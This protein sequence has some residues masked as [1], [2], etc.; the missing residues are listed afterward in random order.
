MK[1]LIEQGSVLIRCYNHTLSHAPVL[2]KTQQYPDSVAKKA[3][4]GVHF[5]YGHD[6]SDA[7]GEED[8]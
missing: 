3:C 5:T 4:A 8:R 6:D 1:D 7:P 2:H